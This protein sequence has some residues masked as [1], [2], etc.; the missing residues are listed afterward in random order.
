MVVPDPPHRL[1]ELRQEAPVVAASVQ[2]GCAVPQQTL[3]SQRVYVLLISAGGCSVRVSS[4]AEKDLQTQFCIRRI[5]V[6]RV[7]IEA[8]AIA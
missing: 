1:G 7:A 3:R 4:L 8:Q 6:N 5:L 2:H